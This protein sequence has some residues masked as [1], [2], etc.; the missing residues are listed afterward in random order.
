MNRL[1]TPGPIAPPVPILDS[2]P[3]MVKTVKNHY[4]AEVVKGKNV[5]I[6]GASTGIGEH[7]AYQYSRLGANVI[8]TARREQRLKEVMFNIF[9][10]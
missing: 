6:T 2:L 5:V 1:R 7:L 8:I 4:I 10:F 3:V 9:V